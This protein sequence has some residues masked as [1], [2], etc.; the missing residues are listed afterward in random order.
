[1]LLQTSIMQ[2]FSVH[3]CCLCLLNQLDDPKLQI[4]LINDKQSCYGAE[5]LHQM[6]SD[7]VNLTTCCL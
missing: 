4:Q 1:M 5:I 6:S 2:W 3:D 7:P